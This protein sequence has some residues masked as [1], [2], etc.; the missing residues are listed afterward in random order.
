MLIRDPVLQELN[1]RVVAERGVAA[2]PVVEPFDVIEQIGDRHLPRRIACAVQ[3]FVLQAVEETLRGRVVP[4]I[5]LAAHRADHAVVAELALEG[6]A[7][8]LGVPI[9]VMNQPRH[10]FSAGP[11]HRQRIGHDGRRH[12][13]LNRPADDLA[14]EQG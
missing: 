7:R 4:V 5:S 14:V 1:R 13:R 11:R 3:P 9:R 6:L 10:R 12:P 8:M 2:A